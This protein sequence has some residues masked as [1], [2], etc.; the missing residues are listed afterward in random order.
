MTFPGAVAH[1][2]HG[3]ADASNVAYLRTCVY[4]RTVFADG[5]AN[6]RLLSSKSKVAPLHEL[7][8]PRKELCAALLLTKLISQVIDALQMPFREVVLWS[9][10][11]IVLA[12]LKK[13][14]HLLQTFVRNR[15]ATIQSESKEYQWRYIRSAVNPA[16]IVSRGQLPEELRQNNLWWNGPQFLTAS[17]Y[18]VENTEEIPEDSLPEMNFKVA[19]PAVNSESFPFFSK[20]SLFRKIQRIMGYVL[21]FIDNCRKSRSADCKQGINFSVQELR[22]SSEAII[23]AMQ[24]VHFGDEIQR[25]ISKRPCKRLGNLNPV[26][27]DGLLRV[28]WITRSCLSQRSIRLFYPT[29]IL[30]REK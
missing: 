18:S 9:D 10:S 13:P 17:E 30:Q 6:L 4:L 14:L 29:R 23:R 1:E 24:Q 12:W 20:F 7:S 11:T 5:S 26:Y 22:R 3:F 19:T 25:V 27:E 2:L 21:R 16:D 15:V 8:I 28:G